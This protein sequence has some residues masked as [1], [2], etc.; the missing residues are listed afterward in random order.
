MLKWRVQVKGECTGSWEISV[1]REDNSHGMLSWGWFDD[2]KILISHNG[3]PCRWPIPKYVFDANIMIANEIC[4]A[5]NS[6]ATY[7]EVMSIGMEEK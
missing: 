6:G 2:K 7:S 3:G 4:N 1:V 5:L